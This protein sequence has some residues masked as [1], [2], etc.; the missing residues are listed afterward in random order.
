MLV[1]RG[2]QELA[3]GGGVADRGFGVDAEDRGQVQ[4]V[5]AVGEGFFE[6]PVAAQAFQGGGVAAE[7]VLGPEGADRAGLGRGLLVDQQ[8]GVGG[9][10]PAAVPVVQPLAQEL[11]GEVV[12]GPD[13]VG[14]DDAPVAGSWRCGET[15]IAARSAGSPA[16]TRAVRRVRR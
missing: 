16:V 7:R 3:G 14:D 2:F 13:P 4:R 5:A 10:W 6:L 1:G 15:A 8:V 11:V 12:D 9:A